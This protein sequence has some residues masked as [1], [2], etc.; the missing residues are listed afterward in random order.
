[1]RL[2]PTAKGSVTFQTSSWKLLTLRPDPA[3]VGR[4]ERYPGS[5]NTVCLRVAK[6]KP[7]AE[8]TPDEDVRPLLDSSEA[9]LWAWQRD[10]TPWTYIIPQHEDGFRRLWSLRLLK[11]LTIPH[12]NSRGKTF[13]NSD[14][15]GH[16]ILNSDI[17]TLLCVVPLNIH[18]TI[19]V[20]NRWLCTVDYIH[21]YLFKLFGPTA[22]CMLSVTYAGHGIVLAF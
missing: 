8:H 9:K 10:G 13:R 2:A 14:M 20:V 6:I 19:A 12:G 22:S 7:F 21:L 16:A 17:G 18:V 1:M 15:P 5:G 4:F 3:F 11:F